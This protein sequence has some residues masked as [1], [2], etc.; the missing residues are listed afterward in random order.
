MRVLD[1]IRGEVQSIEH[2]QPEQIE[3]DYAHRRRVIFVPLDDS[4]PLHTT[5]FERHNLPKGAIGDDHATRVNPEMAREPVE[6]PA[7]VVD[8]LCCHSLRQRGVHIAELSRVSGIHVLRQPVDLGLGEPEGLGHVLEH[9]SRPVGDDVRHHR[10]AF[11]PVA[12]VAV[13]DHLLP[14][15]GLEVDVDVGGFPPLLGEESLEGQMK[16]YRIDPGQAYAS[17]NCGV[18]S[19]PPY[20]TVDVLSASE[21]D[22]IL[23]YQEI[24][25][26]AESLDD[27][28][29]VLDAATGGRV[30]SI[31][32]AR[33]DLARTFPG[34]MP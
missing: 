4:P 17:T 13:L 10:G 3:L 6:P 25:R 5:P 33:V 26:E 16:S 11:T 18:G 34:E 19:R 20:L 12:A 27:V 32:R 21:V 23:H 8:H 7:D 9:R 1:Q 30:D 15:V 28:E 14:S 22:Q 31:V 29:L 24:A 2:S